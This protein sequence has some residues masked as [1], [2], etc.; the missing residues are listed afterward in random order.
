MS[1]ILLDTN[2][3]SEL[4]KPTPNENVIAFLGEAR[5]LWVSTVTLHELAFGIALLPEGR[6]RSAIAETIA[7]FATAYAD[8]IIPLAKDEADRAA[9]LRAEAQKSGRTVSLGDA[10]IAGTAAAHGLTVATRNVSDFQGLGVGG[11]NPWAG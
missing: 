6:R 4:T 3:I 9:L 7:A 10:L 2:V 11:V 8:R 1:G 5:E